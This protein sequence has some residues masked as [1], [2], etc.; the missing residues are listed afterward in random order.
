MIFKPFYLFICFYAVGDG[1]QTAVCM[2]AINGMYAE[3]LPG[4]I[5]MKPFAFFDLI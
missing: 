3:V 2:K 5:K 1:R 4:I